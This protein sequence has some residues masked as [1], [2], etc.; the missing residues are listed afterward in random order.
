MLDF[1]RKD[2][3]WAA[4][5]REPPR[6]RFHLKTIQD[7]AISARLEHA[8]GMRI[9]EI[10]GGASRVL[11][12]LAL[13]NECTN[14]EK[15]EGAGNGPKGEIAVNGVNNVHAFVG[16]F[17]PLLPP[18]SFDV[19]FSISVVEHV[20]A[21]DLANFHLD[22]LRILKAGGRFLHAIDIYL[23][24]QPTGYVEARIAAYREWLENPNVEPEGPLFD[25][26]YV[27]S[28]D[29]ASNP[30]DVMFDWG[31]TAPSLIERRKRAQCVS[32]ILAGRRRAD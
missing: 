26:P 19:V 28:A 29:M 30:D 11:P 15:F 23:E 20:P 4:L 10:G 7:Y 22:Q 21:S 13:R 24:S 8:S 6:G 9:A 16:E 17:S 3:L 1:I 2:E 31:R 5:D 25:G 18:S 27:F 14:I 32:L 12:S